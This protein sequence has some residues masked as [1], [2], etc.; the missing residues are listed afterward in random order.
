MDVDRLRPGTV[1][2]APDTIL[3]FEFLLDSNLLEKHLN[4]PNPDPSPI[5]LILKLLAVDKKEEVI[6]LDDENGGSEGHSAPKITK[7]SVA[8]KILILRIMAF[9]NWDLDILES[10]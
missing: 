7:K 3:W 9:L 10:K 6:V 4:K 2:L 1:P 8:I 5:D